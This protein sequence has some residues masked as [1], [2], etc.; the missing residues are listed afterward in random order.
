MNKLDYALKYAGLGIRV[1]PIIKNT[2][3]PAVKDWPDLATTDKA[4]IERWWA[5]EDYN[6]GVATGRGVIAVDADVKG[7]K[8]GLS[9]L[10]AL[11]LEMLPQSFRTL[12]PSSG[13][14]VLL[15]TKSP[16]ANRVDSIEGYR[17]IDIRGENGYVLGAGSEI[18]GVKY[19]ILSNGGIEDMP[20]EFNAVLARRSQHKQHTANP[21]TELDDEISLAK[22]RTWLETSAPDAIE[23]A[24]GDEATFRTAAWLRDLGLSEPAA[25]EHMLDHWN[26]RQSPPWSPDDLAIKVANAYQYATGT[27][28][29]RSVNADFEPVDLDIGERPVD[30]PVAPEVR[31]AADGAKRRSRFTVFR[32]DKSE[33]TAMHTV[34]HPIVEGVLNKNTFALCYGK[35]GA[36]KTFNL[37]DMGM[38]IALGKPWANAYNTVKGTVFYIAAEGGTSIHTRVAVA[39][40]RHDAPEDTPFYLLPAAVDLVSSDAD[41]KEIVRL[42]NMAAAKSDTPLALIVIDTLNRSMGGGDENSGVDMGLFIKHVGHIMNET[43]ASVMVVHHTG[44]DE[45]KGARGHSSLLGALDTELFISTEGKIATTKQRDL[46]E[47]DCVA[48]FGLVD[49]TIGQ[50]PNGRPLTSAAVAYGEMGEFVE[51]MPIT[52]AEMEFYRVFEAL[53]AKAMTEGRGSVVTWQEWTVGYLSHAKEIGG[54]GASERTMVKW[55]QGVLSAGWVVKKKR[56]A[57]ALARRDR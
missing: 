24:G 42:A 45:A 25:L 19:E 43:G 35:P 12:T 47:I 20:D 13:I 23:G 14:H 10:E 30:A 52:D 57:Y 9:S 18:D 38:C 8:P 27:W 50:D 40:R 55:M 31:L 56:G 16:V 48:S 36:A 54:G 37:L 41:A 53:V 4:T 22:A 33:Q 32:S 44:K 2:K 28:G 21:V 46:T 11:D 51:P 49:L 17:G 3:E 26:D 5:I 29:G 15:R 7:G 34:F 1:F 39:R 6:I